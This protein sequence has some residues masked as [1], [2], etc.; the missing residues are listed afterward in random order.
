MPFSIRWYDLKRLNANDSANQVTVTKTFYPF[1]STTVQKGE[2][3]KAYTLAP[4]G[5]HYAIPIS[6]DEISKSYNEIVQ[7]TY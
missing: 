2:P 3:T 1:N 4:N 5:R 7:N 6:N